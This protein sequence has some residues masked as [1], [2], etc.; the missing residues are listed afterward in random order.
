MNGGFHIGKIFG[1]NIKADWSWLI[2]F[3]LVT[4]NLSV[5]LFPVFH[6]DW[7]STLNWSLGIAASL[8]FFASVLAHE[9][10]HSLVAKSK[11]IPVSEITLFLFGG[12]SNIEK[13]PE[14]PATEFWMAIVGPATSIFLGLIFIL[15]TGYSVNLSTIVS[16]N[17]GGAFSQIN[18]LAT[19]FLWLGSVN[20]FV[21]IFNLTPGFP[22]DGGRVLRSIIWGMTKDFRKATF[23]STMAGKFIAWLFIFAGIS[24][25]FGINVP[26]FGSGIIGGVWITFIGWF[27]KSAATQSYQKVIIEDALGKVLVSEIM[28]PSFPLVSPEITASQLVYSN[29]LGS[30]ERVFVVSKDEKLAGLVSLDDVRK[31]PRDE[32]DQ[33]TVNEIMTP[34]DQ[35]TLVSPSDTASSALNKLADRNI[36]QMPVIEKGKVVG[37]LRRR[38]I[39]WWLRLHI[40][41]DEEK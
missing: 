8:L 21:G 10:A 41:K 4:W 35:L 39:I 38:D 11:G 33:M 20:I 18:P 37:M 13:E 36:G 2:I 5:G 9:I 32:W 19:L 30:D 3:A 12:V 27:L 1:I 28:R 25:I 6:P 24:M 34:K 40:Q 31:V 26:I 16:G 15:F 29:I 7:S 17:A 23:Y 14:S 22:L